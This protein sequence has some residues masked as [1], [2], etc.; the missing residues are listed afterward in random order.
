MKQ[1]VVNELNLTFKQ[2]CCKLACKYH[3]KSCFLEAQ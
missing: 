2:H 1:I 3:I